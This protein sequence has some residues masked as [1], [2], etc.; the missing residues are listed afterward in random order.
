MTDRQLHG[1]LTI[2]EKQS[3]TAAADA[4]YISQSALSQQMQ[5]LE[6]ELGFVLFD[7]STRRTTLTEA[8]RSFYQNAQKL[9]SLYTHALSEGQQMQE[10]STHHAK[11]FCIGCLGDQYLQIWTELRRIALPLSDQYAPRAVRYET[12]DALYTALL[13]GEVQLAALLENSDLSR[14][15]LQFS[16]FAQVPE[17]C[18]FAAYRQGD[19]LPWHDLTLPL[20]LEELRSHHLIAFHNHPG[21]NLYEDHL[22][23]YLRDGAFSYEY[24]DPKNFATFITSYRKVALLLPAIQYSGH[25][26]A[27]PLDWQGGA[28]LGF[29]TAPNADKS[30]LDYAQYIKE[31]LTAIPNFWEPLAE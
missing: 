6:R 16:P 22:R 11:F 3:F 18:L 25:A 7:R 13:R 5:T 29:V 26:L 2:A 4:L 8:G 15:G 12:K 23:N 9:Q 20:A 19:E 30:V 10:L 17:L 31:H 21:S 14:I 1:F 28:K 24:V 27:V